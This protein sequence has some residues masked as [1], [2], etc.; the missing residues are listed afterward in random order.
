M[1][2]QK[3]RHIDLKE[4]SSKQ[5]QFQ[6]ELQNRFASLEDLADSKTL[7]DE[8][9]Q[10]HNI[11][12]EEA[13]KLAKS[14]KETVSISGSCEEI[15]KLNEKRKALKPLRQKSKRNQIEYTELNKTIRK[16]RRK[17][18][19]EYRTRMVKEV[20]ESNK[21]PKIINR[22]LEGGRKLLSSLKTTDGTEVTDKVKITATIEQFYSELYSSDRPDWRT[23][24]DWDVKAENVPP[25]MEDE[26]QKAV[27]RT[28]KGKAPGEDQL[29]ADILKLGG[30]ATIKILT[31]LF[32]KIMELEQ[33]PTQ[34][35]ESKVIILFKKG[36]TKDIK[37]YRP[38]SLLPHMYKVF[39]RIILARM[40]RELDEN[41]PREQAGFRA[42]FRTSD[43]LHT[44]SQIIEKAKEYRFNI[45]L[46][47]VD[48]EKAFD[49]LEHQSLL[50]ALERQVS[51]AKYIRLIKAIYKDPSAKIHLENT[52]TEAIKILKGV[53][54]GDPISPKLFT[55]AME[56]T[57]RSLDWQS[58]GIRIDGE[59]LTHLRFAD[60]ILLVSHEPLELQTMMRELS[61]ESQ[62]AGLKMNIKKTK[63][64]MSS[65]L[66]DHT[67]TV[68]GR[69]IEKV[70]HYTY[71]GKNISLENETA[72]EVKRR[73]QL[74]AYLGKVWQAQRCIP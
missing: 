48:Y 52:T 69:I 13:E 43:H 57:F 40:Q 60:D 65:R 16:M 50:H 24:E 11:I 74:I 67:I 45:C 36:D 12:L 35:N 59:H 34:W 32:N 54:Q 30:Q 72:G 53:R 56:N 68:E 20:L 46:G 55:A 38:I 26:V 5:T 39:T 1:K 58:Y 6:L 49:S 23:T 63:V 71:L 7:D 14:K 33:V 28:K 10:I 21:G 2:R 18:K 44:L 61:E 31:K 37:N 15:C 22:K 29:T 19:R 9:E 17:K 8:Y 25:I 3:K 66:K 47:F 73:I 64:M 42:G 51:D 70:E 27:E 62:K 41:Q 4:L